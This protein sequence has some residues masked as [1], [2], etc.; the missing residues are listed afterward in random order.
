[1]TKTAT[2]PGKPKTKPTCTRDQLEKAVPHPLPVRIG[3]T[4]IGYATFKDFS[5][6]SYGLYCGGKVMLPLEGGVVANLQVG[7]NMTVIGSKP[8]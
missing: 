1:M 7:M 6:G 8:D 3:D 4:V 2:K 5:S